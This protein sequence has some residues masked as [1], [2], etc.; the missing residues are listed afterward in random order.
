MRTLLLSL[1]G[2]LV[3]LTLQAQVGFN[4]PAGVRPTQDYEIYS[5]NGFIVQEK[6]TPTTVDPAA[7][8]RTM[9]CA[10]NPPSLTQLAGI[11][12]DPSGDGNYL[13]N[14]NY[15]CTQVIQPSSASAI[16]GIEITFEDLNLVNSDRIYISGQNS[17]EQLTFTGSALPNRLVIKWGYVKIDFAA[18]AGGPGGRGFRLRWRTLFAEPLTIPNRTLIGYSSLQLDLYHGSFQAGASNIIG[19]PYNNGVGIGN[20]Y[21]VALGVGNTATGGYATAIGH[22]NTANGAYSTAM[23]HYVSSNGYKGT[24]IIG[25]SDPLSQGTTTGSVTDQFVARFLNGY[26][27][28]TSGNSNPGTSTVRTGVQIGKGQNSWATISD[29]TKK[30]R[31]LPIAGADLLRKIGAMRLT[32]WNYKGQHS[33]RHYGPMAQDFYAAFGHDELGQIGCDTLIYSNDLAGVTLS[34]VQALIHEIA[35]LKQENSQLKGRLDR[36]DRETTSR[37]NLLEQ[38]VFVRSRLQ[39][40]A[41]RRP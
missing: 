28:L 9:S 4:S 37:L 8:V 10:A 29:S 21:N 3:A 34:A 12:K 40:V 30:E 14:T 24:F 26:Y 32:T 6:Y 2:V 18:D 33:I 25:D 7:T 35:V 41:N 38:R 5:K 23:G 11:L 36:V 22:Y 19:W 15:F 39:T 20:L 13:P 31:F 16:N 27:L 17:S 1:L